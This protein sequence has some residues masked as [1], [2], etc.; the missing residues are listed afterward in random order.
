MSFTISDQGLRRVEELLGL[1]PDKGGAILPILE[2]VQ[3]EFGYLP[4]EAV[5]WVAGKVGTSPAD[6]EGYSVRN[7]GDTSFGTVDLR[8]ATAASINMSRIRRTIL[9]VWTT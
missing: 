1:Y 5:P 2:L 7:Y 8:T 6:I 3:S 9:P 4:D